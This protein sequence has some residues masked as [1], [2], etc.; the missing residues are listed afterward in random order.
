MKENKNEF[1]EEISDE[2]FIDFV[3]RV[4]KLSDKKI[5]E[6]WNL[7][8]YIYAKDNYPHR[9]EK[10]KAMAQQYIDKIRENLDSA[11]IVV[12]NLWS[13]TKTEEIKKNLSIVENS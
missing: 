3:R 13:E 1:G 10:F 5:D 12:G 8:G 6:F 9:E 4:R 11:K 7:C 2:E